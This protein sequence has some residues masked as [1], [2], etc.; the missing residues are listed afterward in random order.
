[1]VGELWLG[2]AG[3]ALGYV[4]RPDLTATAFVE[5]AR[6]RRY[7]SGDLGRWRATG[8]IEIL[9]RTDDQVKLNGIRV[10]LGEIEHA[11]GSHPDIAQA[12]ALLDGDARPSLWAFVRPLP[13]R[14]APAEESWREY[15]ASRLPAYMIPSTVIAIPT[16]PLSNSGKVDKAELKKLLA[17]RSPRCEGSPPGDGLEAEIACLWSELLGRVPVQGDDNFFSLGGHS[18]LAIDVAY[19]LEKTL[20]HPVS[21]RELFAAPTLRGFAQRVGQLGKATLPTGV[22]SDRAT[23]GQREFWVAE[24]AGLDTRGFNIPL[25]LIASGEVQSAWTFLVAR[26]DALRTSFHEDTNGVLRRCVR[27]ELGSNLEISNQP[28]RPS[29]MAHVR[30]R[31]SEP[32]VM[33]SPPLWRA[34]LVHVAGMEQP[35]FWLVLHHSVGD[36]VSLGV[37]AEE[38]S[39]LLEGGALAPVAGQFD[40]SA[41][42][43]E[44]YLS[45]RAC[46]EDARYWRKILEQ[47]SFDDWSLDLPRPLGRTARHAKG[48]H[49]FR[50]RLDASIAT[51]LR[52][53]AQQNGAS[54][55][56]LMLTIMAQEVRR[57]TGRPEF[58]LGTAASTRNSAGEARIVGYY[59]N[60]LPVPCRVDRSES[61]EQA[62][63]AMQ[64][65]LAEGLQHARYP[66][67]RMYRDFR[68]DQAEA[69]HPARYPLFDLVVAENPGAPNPMITGGPYE[70]RLNAPAQDMV[71][72]HESQ[73][74][75]SLFLQWYVNAAIYEKETAEAWID[76][77]A[78]WER[79]PALPQ[80]APSLPA[81]FEHWARVQPDR[82]A[83]VTERGAQSYAV[84]NARSN[85]LAH[86]LLALGVER[87]EP[88][89]VLTDRSFA[90]PETVLAIWKSGG[91]YLP[92]ANDLPPDRLAFIAR[93]AGIRIVVVLDGHEP[94]A[95]LVETGCSIFR[96]ES[97]SEAFLSSHGSPL[98]VVG[99]G[100]RGS[101]LAYIIY[102]SGSTGVPKGVMLLHQG[103]NN[104]GVAMD[105]T[106]DIRSDDRALLMASPAFD[107]WIADLAMAWT[108]GAAVV[109][110]LRGEMDD[111]AGMR[112]KMVRL[113]VSTAA[114]TPSYLRLFEQ[115]DFPGLRL[116]ITVGEPPHRADALH[117]AARLRYVNGY[118]PTENTVAVSFGHVTSEAHRLTAGKPLANTSVHIRNSAG[119][120]VPPGATGLIWL[121][122]M[123][124][125]AGYLNRPELTAASFVETPVGRLYCSGD[126][127]RWTHAGELEILGRSDGQVKLGGQRVELG[128]LE[129]TLEAHPGV[130]QGVAIV[131]TQPD[132]THSLWAFVCLHSEA[133]EP[134]Q[135][136]WHDYLSATL[137]SYMLPS[138]VLRVPAIPVNTAGKVDRAALLLAAAEQSVGLTEPPRDGIEQCIAQVWAERLACRLIGRDDNFF[139][140][141]GNSLRAISVVNR[142]RREFQCTI[143]DLFEHPRLADFARACQPR[144]EHLRMVIQ[145]ARQHWQGYQD[146]LAAYEAE[147]DTTLTAAYRD[148]KTRNQ[149]YERSDVGGPRDYQRVLLTGATGYLGSY[150]L[151][152]LLA[153]P[154][155]QVSVLVRSGDG[156]MARARLGE[157]LCHYFGPDLGAALRD[158]PRL[159]VLA[160]DLRRDDLGLSREARDRLANTLQAIFHSAAT[161][162]HF[163]HYWEFH[164]DNVA[165]TGRLLK[166]AAHCGASPAD[167]HFVSTLSACGK[168]PED[169]FRLFTEYDSVPDA[170]D[171]NYYI[172]SKQEAE[173]LVVAARGELA[174]ACIH[175]VGSLVF[176]AEGGPLQ[177]NIVE[178]AFFR[179]LAAFLHLGVT[180]DDS[181]LWLCHVDVVARALVLLAGTADLTNETHHLENAR[182]DTLA[183]FVTV[184]QGVRACRFD[185][186]LARLEAAVDEPA[187]DAALSETLE[188]F[189]LYRG[190]SPQARSRRLE[191]VS[192]RTQA[193]LARL[194]LVWP[195]VPAAGQA[196]MLRRAAQLFS[197]PSLT[198]AASGGTS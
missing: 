55:H 44:I 38:L 74:D 192:V 98:E 185:A 190:L 131:K 28:D 121:G 32:F 18:L 20:G 92:L 182:R 22:P 24:Q 79:G 159:T 26:H 51:G 135:A 89:G 123:G 80:L 193:L 57:R 130:R 101:D 83:L 150:L 155:R 90:L 63:R 85:A 84:L 134:T 6:G 146:G 46:Q 102:T 141:G 132:G 5:T 19:R 178:N 81:R 100:V 34:G 14:E 16:I 87:Q 42:Q 118:G 3:L 174:N 103:L 143:N 62:L 195:P 59:V 70:L 7:R 180:P 158:D 8:E 17:G 41:G 110:I 114:M 23:E 56:A 97:L 33:E 183:A 168:A 50:I 13:G 147:R 167:F 96:P 15:L 172:R 164:A 91:C 73:P 113:G 127:G 162:K 116:L 108:A 149:A 29:A 106:L 86:A 198:N 138:A 144:P 196:E 49:S 11:L 169:G 77:L 137:P 142:L 72:V 107:A 124:L 109:P 166:L 105:A 10:E 115:A 148:Y 120:P 1:M 197:G 48:A 58:L 66:F 171:E 53:F 119:E 194:G 61:V 152:E 133:P 71:L 160:G 111:I 128:E 2:G 104:L 117:Y 25:T 165:A 21:A 170:L 189:G 30:A 99:D 175:R 9:G 191:I 157:V 40:Q 145:S 95:S 188:N 75:G 37:L 52:D 154:D 184:A 67:A 68:Q 12:V 179:Q 187:M 126:L 93:D 129:H 4:G 186:F 125:A 60:M 27:P 47:Q 82:P 177:F 173:Q 54:L 94:P 156:Q 45:G 31:Q 153:D 35:V 176:A 122:G 181:H 161:V 65:S 76:S 64:R 140:L 151:R 39:T 43:E 112:D 78:G 88:V 136:A 36:G 139:D 69:P 163:G